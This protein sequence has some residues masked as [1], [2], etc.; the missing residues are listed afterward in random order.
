MIRPLLAL[1]LAAALPAA[2]LDDRIAKILRGVPAGGVAAVA[3]AR[4]ADGRFIV[5]SGAERSVVPA[6]T[7]KLAV[8]AAALE[9][10]GSRYRFTTRVVGLGPVA[11]GSVPGIGVIAG[12]SPC[13][14]EH[15]TDKQP[16][17][18]FTAWADRLRAA[19]VRRIAGDV[20]IDARRFAGPIRPPTYPMSPDNAIRWFTAPA[21]AFAW[22]DNCIEVRVVPTIPGEPARVEVR[23]RSPRI[24]IVNRT[25]TVRT[26]GDDGLT[27]TRAL[28]ANTITVSGRYAKITAWNPLS[29]H[30]DPDLLAG[31]HLKAVLRDAGIPVD[32]AVRLGPVDPDGP[33]LVRQDDPLLPALAIL[34]QRS[35]N[36]YGEQILRVIANHAGQPGSVAAGTPLVEATLA[37]LLGSEHGFTV[38]DGS[39]LS[40]GNRATA[41][42]LVRL[43][44]ALTSRHGETFTATLR[45][46]EAG[47]GKALVKTGSLAIAVSLA[48]IVDPPGGPRLAFAMVFNAGEGGGVSWA[49]ALRDRI[50]AELGAG[51]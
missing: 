35:Q 51:P 34:N 28:D 40:Y 20:V 48:G 44:I 26:G 10:L 38:L 12:G 31:D 21:S 2:D 8:T 39:G 29:I 37:D 1:V 42:G 46:R 25:T 27:A 36:F 32:G 43:I 3:V 24:R 13:L 23:P 16:D 9:R 5:R 45:P 15:F 14:D 47:P 7:Q 18:I 33:E 50:L 49:P 17:R 22:N 4:V 41:T 6:S 30:S 19:G 11:G